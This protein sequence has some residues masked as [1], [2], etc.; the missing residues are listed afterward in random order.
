MIP[1]ADGDSSPLGQR[2][3]SVL[4]VVYRLW[5]S[6]RLSQ[7]WVVGWLPKSVS[8]LGDGLFLVEAWFSTA[9]DIEEVLSGTRG[10]Q[11]HVMV[12]DVIKSFDSVDRSILD[13]ALGR[14]GLVDWFRRA[15]FSFHSQV[16]LRFKLAAGLGE[17]W[18]RDVGL[19]HRCPLSMGFIVALYVPWF[20]HL[21]SLPDGKPQLKS[22]FYF[23]PSK[24]VR[25]AMKLWDISGDGSFWKVQLD[26]RDLGG[27]LDFTRRARAGTLSKQVGE[28]TIGVAAVGTLPL[29]FQVKVGLVRGEY[30]PAG[31][32][33]AEAPY[34]SSSSISAVTAAIV[35]AVWSSKMPLANAPAI[36]NLLD[37]LVGIDNAVYVFWARFR[38][39]RRYLAY[40]LDEEPRIFGC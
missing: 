18:C 35:R 33:T 7:E 14:L 31:L 30:L 16:R 40:C 1:K 12:A 8:S 9:L 19:L 27:H 11:L 37:G 23:C 26:V 4:P 32:H 25:K 28:A 10:D 5:A 36:L 24:S 6:L 13:C 34:V 15:Y 22:A 21:E 2:P 39:M 17:P 3:L 38:M 29:G 20:R